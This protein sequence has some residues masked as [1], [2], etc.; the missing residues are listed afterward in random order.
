MQMRET[1]T[2]CVGGCDHGWSQKE[3]RNKNGVQTPGS[4]T[5]TTIEKEFRGRCVCGLG[6]ASFCATLTLSLFFE[7]N[8]FT[9]S[10]CH[11]AVRME[12]AGPAHL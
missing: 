10:Q 8:E 5:L 4:G 7:L 12:V 1:A 3:N 11:A 6:L 9:D 2:E